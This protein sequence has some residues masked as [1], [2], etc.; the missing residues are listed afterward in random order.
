MTHGVDGCIVWN[1][2]ISA[3][4]DCLSVGVSK[5]NKWSKLFDNAERRR[6]QMVQ[7]Y[8]PGGGNV[9]SHDGTLAPPGEYD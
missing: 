8:S 5:D 7:S 6:R 4:G 1:A 9:S 2:H 3:L